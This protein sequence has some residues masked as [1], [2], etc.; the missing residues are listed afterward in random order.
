MFSQCFINSQAEPTIEFKTSYTNV[1][2]LCLL[3]V[4]FLSKYQYEKTFCTQSKLI[5]YPKSI[6]NYNF[7]IRKNL[8][9]QV[10]KG[11][12]N[13]KKQGVVEYISYEVHIY[14]LLHPVFFSF[15]SPLHT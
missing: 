14:T 8:Y 10:C 13:G 6:K 2:Y 12:K 5:Y 4:L 11:E 15:F 3:I 7:F 9:S 1:N